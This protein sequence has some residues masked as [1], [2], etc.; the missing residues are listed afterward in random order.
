MASLKKELLLGLGSAAALAMGS[1]SNA[2]PMDPSEVDI[3]GR[4]SVDVQRAFH[5]YADS[6]NSSL[7]WYVAKQGT[8]ALS[9]AGN[10][11]APR[12]RF[13]V[14]AKRPWSGVLAGEELVYFGGAFDT[15]GI[16]GDLLKLEAEARG[17][18][19][20]ISPAPASKATTKFLATGFE[21]G[22]DGRVDTDCTFEEWTGPG[23]FTVLVPKCEALNGN[24][25]YQATDFMY[26]FR[27]VTPRGESTASQY[28]PFQGT[29][30][31]EWTFTIEDMM[32]NGDNWDAN[33]QAVTEWELTTE[34]KTRIAR[35]NI[36]WKR[37]FEQASTF[38]AIHNWACVDIEVGTFFR[39]L[40]DNPDGN[41]GITVEYL[42][43]DG[44]YSDTPSNNNQFNQAVDALV[45]EVRDE[46]FNEIRDYGQS[47]LGDV[48][49]EASAVFTLRANYEKLIFERNETRYLSW[50]PGTAIKNSSTNMAVQCMNGG[51]G[52]PVT[53]NMEDETCAAMA[54]E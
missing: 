40:V 10:G 1:V 16:R 14:Y 5:L 31:P 38:A 8:I 50:N 45:K 47:Q 21:I 39:R 9:G 11:R 33:L 27:A 17:Q 7:V 49:R 46:L 41:S 12:P 24:G 26:Q 37:T 44:S 15:T 20:R 29:S 36:D 53:W 19:L 2:A 3:S 52:T 34:R 35:V 54:G 48:D 18:G 6:D 32:Y 42:Q 30:M 22:N 13:S 51:F 43:E 4:F 25:E 23:G 28:I